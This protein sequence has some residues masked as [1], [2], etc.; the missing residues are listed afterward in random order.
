LKTL[1]SNGENKQMIVFE[2]LDISYHG[3]PMTEDII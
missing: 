3:Y 2:L 1:V